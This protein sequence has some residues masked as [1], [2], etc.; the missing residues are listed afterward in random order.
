[1]RL[2]LGGIALVLLG[3]LTA[4]GAGDGDAKARITKSAP[5]TPERF[6]ACDLLTQKQRDAAAD[7]AVDYPGRADFYFP[8]WMCEFGDAPAQTATSSV[9]YGA[10]RAQVWAEKLPYVI[11][12]TPAKEKPRKL[13]AA[14]LAAADMSE[15]E[16]GLLD[17]DAA[18]D[19]WIAMQVTI[20]AKLVHG[21]SSWSGSD[22]KYDYHY[23]RATTCSDGVFADVMVVASDADSRAGRARAEKT[24]ATVH[25]KG[26]KAL[27]R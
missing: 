5:R 3:T 14:V 19:L 26:V 22:D 20:N 24:L 17:G 18:C 21:V 10:M 2:I 7:A 13:L 16:L 8:E 9:L 27:P 6:V 23:A 1:M 15:D 12:T 4:C 25:A 11:D